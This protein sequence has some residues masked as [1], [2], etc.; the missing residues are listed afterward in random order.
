[1]NVKEEPGS[2]TMTSGGIGAIGSS[3][4]GS[5]MGTGVSSTGFSSVDFQTRPKCYM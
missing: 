1:M 3:V 2:S 4:V 5:T